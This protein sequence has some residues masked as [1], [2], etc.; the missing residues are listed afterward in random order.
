[1]CGIAGLVARPHVEPDEHRVAAMVDALARRGPDGHGLHRWGSA[2][3]GHRRL[4]ILDLSERGRQPMLSD[5]GAIGVVFNGAIYNYRDLRAELQRMGCRFRSTTDTEVL[6]HGYRAWGVDALVARLA[7]MFAFA[8]WDDHERQL[9]LVRD[10]LGVKPLAFS[11]NCDSIAFAST[12]GSLRAGGFGGELD[13]QALADY[14]EWGVV[15]EQRSIYAGI[16]KLP[17]A[18]IA[19]WKD[20]VLRQRCY[21]DPASAQ[22]SVAASFQDTVAET[23]QRFLEAVRRRT[24]ADVPIGALLSGGIDSALVCWGL[25][26]AGANVTVYTYSAA[27]HPEDEAPE[28]L[29]T[30][31]E[32]GIDVTVLDGVDQAMDSLTELVQA[33]PEPFACGS[34]LGMLR[35]ARAARQSATVLITGDGGDDAFLGYPHHLHLHRAQQLARLVPRGAAPMAR[36]LASGPHAN[37]PLRRATNFAGY[38]MGGLGPF[39]SVRNCFRSLQ[40][41]GLVGPRLEGFLPASQEERR[42][43]DWSG[44]NVLDDYLCYARRHQFVAEYLAK[45]DG[46]TMYHALEARSPFLDHELWDFASALP[47]SRRL[48]GGSLKAI[49]R[50]IAGRRVSPRLAR[51]SKRG[52]EVPVIR[53]LKSR[54]REEAL[55]ACEA[56]AV[57]LD[58]WLDVRALAA[59]LD[60][61][62]APSLAVWYAIVLARWLQEQRQQASASLAAA[63][64]GTGMLR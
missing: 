60:R 17:P 28:A 62:P 24:E 12:V 46:A 11:C 27:G 56:S 31:R 23:E 57:E 52:F 22:V 63:L 42:R 39:L 49:L 14:L 32:L 8:I 40:E 43:R 37:G 59:T 44:R 7:G 29:L 35:L 16:D 4:A 15:P 33:F 25:R 50:D 20:G 3:L 64:P 9:F 58:G 19:D 34:A 5:D 41:A 51:G 48:H 13:A 18:T 53:W 54:W 61:D 2:V 38:V 10:R 6:L 30:A 1:M 45:V 21:W 26:E 55:G 36:L 47:Y